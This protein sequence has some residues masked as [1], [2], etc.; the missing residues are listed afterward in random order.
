MDF[1]TGLGIILAVI[2]LVLGFTSDGGSIT[3][4]VQP[5]AML[6]VF[7]G[8]LGAT[9]VG[10][11]L[12]QFAGIVKYLKIA[13]LTKKRDA[14]DTIDQLVH[15]ATVARREGILALEEEIEQYDD[16]FLKGGLQLVVDGVDPELVKNMLEIELSAVQE[17]HLTAA[18]I[19]E[20]AG[21]Y[22]PTMGIIGTVMGL[23]H[24]LADLSDVTRLGPQIATA[25]TATLY[26]VAS[27]NIFWLPIATKLKKRDQDEMLIRE[28]M[29]EGILSI[30]AGE[31]PNILGQKLRAF[32]APSNRT[33]KVAA[34]V[35]DAN[36]E[37][38]QS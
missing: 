5:S 3:A 2:S 27:A 26:G 8:T 1:A 12:K 16:P 9:M 11:N 14:L 31:N 21:G 28:I 29:M 37:T 18:H 38:A 6:I 19:F 13:F 30:Q 20:S 25:F 23:V 22:A 36:V 24:V 15:L 10:T 34:K 4:L 35:G 33:R 7:G 32:L 17:R